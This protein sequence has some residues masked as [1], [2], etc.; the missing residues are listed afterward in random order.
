MVIVF[1]LVFKVWL[2]G[3]SIFFL[4]RNNQQRKP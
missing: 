1:I 4:L 2:I 3:K